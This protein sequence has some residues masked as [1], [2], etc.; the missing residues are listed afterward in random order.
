MGRKRIL[1][2]FFSLWLAFI[3]AKKEMSILR[4][5]KD[6]TSKPGETKLRTYYSFINFL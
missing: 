1:M 6:K 5:R 2:T 4:Y 3:L